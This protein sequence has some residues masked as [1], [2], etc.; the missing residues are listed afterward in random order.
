MKTGFTPWCDLVVQHALPVH[1]AAWFALGC[2]EREHWLNLQSLASYCTRV[3]MAW[4]GPPQAHG[5][6]GSPAVSPSRRRRPSRE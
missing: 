5:V 6:T 4:P 1:R 2:L 3:S